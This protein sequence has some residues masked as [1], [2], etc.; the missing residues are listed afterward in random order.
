MDSTET[1]REPSPQQL[2]LPL[3]AMPPARDAI[4]PPAGMSPQHLWLTLLPAERIRVRT[5]L[6]RVLREVVDEP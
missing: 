4:P 1:R 6:L 2:P 3:P 5:T